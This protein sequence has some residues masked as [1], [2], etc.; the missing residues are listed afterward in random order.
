MFQDGLFDSLAQNQNS[1]HI[2]LL[3]AGTLDPL[4]SVEPSYRKPAHYASESSGIKEGK[5]SLMV[6]LLIVS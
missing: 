6:I 4:W 1:R 2:L 3:V 5:P